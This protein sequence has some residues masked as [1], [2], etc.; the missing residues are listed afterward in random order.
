MGIML[1][2]IPLN[3]TSTGKKAIKQIYS[4]KGEAQ[5]TGVQSI[6]ASLKLLFVCLGIHWADCN[7]VGAIVIPFA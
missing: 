7:S 1:L 2:L 6:Y 4:G 3:C 5:S